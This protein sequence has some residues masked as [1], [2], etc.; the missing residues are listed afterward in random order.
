MEGNAWR[1]NRRD[2]TTLGHDTGLAAF[3]RVIHQRRWQHPPP[4]HLSL[5]LCLC[6]L[7][8][9]RAAP[10]A[11]HFGTRVSYPVDFVTDIAAGDF[12]GDGLADIA[13]LGID[14]ASD[15]AVIILFGQANGTFLAQSPA[16]TIPGQFFQF[17][18]IAAGNLRR[19]D[20]FDDLVLLV[21]NIEGEDTLVV[22]ENLASPQPV[23]FQALPGLRPCDAT[24]DICEPAGIAVLDFNGD[25]A[26]DIAVPDVDAGSVWLLPKVGNNFFPLP[27]ALPT[28]R[29]PSMQFSSPAAAAAGLLDGDLKPDLAIALNQDLGVAVHINTQTTSA[30]PTFAPPVVYDPDPSTSKDIGP[31][32][33]AIADFNHD[34]HPDIALSNLGRTSGNVTIHINNGDG[35]F[36]NA[37]EYPVGGPTADDLVAVDL[38]ADG[39]PDIITRNGGEPSD[40]VDSL[41]V[42][43]G[44]GNG[45]FVSDVDL[46]SIPVGKGLADLAVAD[47]N[48]DG[49]PDVAVVEAEDNTVSVLLGGGVN[50]PTFTPTPSPTVTLTPTVTP[51]GTITLTPTR[52]RTP[53]AT[54]RPTLTRT[55]TPSPTITPTVP[56]TGSPT[57]TP[58]ITPT[59]KPGMAG[60]ANCDEA[61]T[62]ADPAAL[63]SKLFNPGLYS[64]CNG[65]DANRDGAV[66]VADFPATIQAI[67]R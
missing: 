20:R 56:Y 28:G 24:V 32:G 4:L 42:L 60:D 11:F 66:S 16:L 8:P 23:S 19:N 22:F 9:A 58:T 67:L 41:T 14:A 55:V 35:T 48:G 25:G 10:P 6:L 54:L 30:N 2:A 13:A 52:T 45:T 49:K 3:F 15:P 62:D 29:D 12:N 53:T 27:Q 5:S 31:T 18:G 36:R 50:P 17:E 38:N 64:E 37:V 65:A 33:V 44:V 26:L 57:P 21:P 43:L 34:N 47:F 63:A 51:T 59:P 7:T 61:L 1:D 39:N 46:M 40:G